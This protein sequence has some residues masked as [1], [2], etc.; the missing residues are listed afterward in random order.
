MTNTT[1]FIIATVIFFAFEC[2]I[3]PLTR[4]KARERENAKRAAKKA[5]EAEK[6]NKN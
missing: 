5:A 6:N 2:F 1:L 4:E 3:N